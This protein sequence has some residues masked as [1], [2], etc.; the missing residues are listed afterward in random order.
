MCDLENY[1]DANTLDFVL[2]NTTI[3]KLLLLRLLPVEGQD[4]SD[5]ELQNQCSLRGE[6]SDAGGTCC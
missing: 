4:E 6:E 1:V 3:A 5:D 2:A